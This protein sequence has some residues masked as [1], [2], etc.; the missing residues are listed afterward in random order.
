MQARLGCVSSSMQEGERA[1][2]ADGSVGPPPPPLLGSWATM[3]VSFTAGR[4]ERRPRWWW[5]WWVAKGCGAMRT[6]GP[7]WH[8][9]V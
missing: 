7:L 3:D 5:W 1:R 9:V 6:D 8:D 4:G 2:R